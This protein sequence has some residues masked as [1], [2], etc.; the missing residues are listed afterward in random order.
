MRVCATEMLVNRELAHQDLMGVQQVAQEEECKKAAR[1]ALDNYNLALVQYMHVHTQMD[2]QTLTHR[3]LMRIL[4]LTSSGGLSRDM[5]FSS[6]ILKLK[7]L[8][9]NVN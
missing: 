9:E 7:C 6:G 2:T 4:T 1:I 5:E 8:I 3:L